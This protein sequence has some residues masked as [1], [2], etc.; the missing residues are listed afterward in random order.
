MG[1]RAGNF[2]RGSG[3]T[4]SAAFRKYLEAYNGGPRVADRDFQFSLATAEQLLEPYKLDG[5]ELTRPFFSAHILHLARLRDAGVLIFDGGED[6]VSPERFESMLTVGTGGYAAALE[7]GVPPTHLLVL[8]PADDSLRRVP[9][10]P[11]A[12]VVRVA[13]SFA[14]WYRKV[15]P[16]R[17]AGRKTTT[18]SAAAKKPKRA[19]KPPTPATLLAAYK[20]KHKV[21]LPPAYTKFIKAYD[22]A[23][24]VVGPEGTPWLMATV[25]ELADPA[26]GTIPGADGKPLPVVRLTKVI[27]DELRAQ[28]S[29]KAI[30]VWGDEKKKFTFARFAKGVCIGH[31]NGDPL[32]LD[33]T[34]GH[35][36]W[37]YSREGQ[38]VGPVADSFALFLKPKPKKAAAPKKTTAKRKTTAAGTKRKPR[39]AATPSTAAEPVVVEPS[40]ELQPPPRKRTSRAKAEAPAKPKP[41][42]K[43]K[44]A[45]K[46]RAK[47]A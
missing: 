19:A 24:P 9:T 4:V 31:A 47:A 23:A 38:Y 44:A 7:K 46:P 37:G 41:P 45:A 40:A 14:K 13:D 22:G 35:S 28:K 17:T 1:D 29:L 2:E 18:A 15:K 42:A 16:K 10:D 39:K 43:P 26:T 12:V 11:P 8:D 5:P 3:R 33:P 25:A 27:A 32:F 36:V 30:P 21:T 6:P 34:D 20:R